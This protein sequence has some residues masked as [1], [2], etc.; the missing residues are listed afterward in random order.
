MRLSHRLGLSALLVAG[1]TSQPVLASP[2]PTQPEAA[3]MTIAFSMPGSDLAHLQLEVSDPAMRRELTPAKNPWTSVGLSAAGGTFLSP[4]GLGLGYLYAGDP[5]RGMW[6][7]LGGFGTVTL[8]VL[9]G[10]ALSQ[11][12]VPSARAGGESAGYAYAFV[13]VPVMA[14]SLIGYYAW[15]LVDVYRTTLRM[16][17]AAASE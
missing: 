12:I 7:G 14:L 4:L 10:Y 2:F 17:E 16:N 15:A 13:G 1:M 11:A 5:E 9:A 3:P 8:G 6:V